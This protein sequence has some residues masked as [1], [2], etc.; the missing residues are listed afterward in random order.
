MTPGAAGSGPPGQRATSLGD[1]LRHCARTAL[2]HP[3][4]I[5]HTKSLAH[6]NH[7]RR[8]RRLERAARRRAASASSRSLV[9]RAARACRYY[10]RRPLGAHAPR[11]GASASPGAADGR[12]VLVERSRKPTIPRGSRSTVSAQCGQNS[13][14]RTRRA[15]ARHTDS[16]EHKASHS[17]R[18]AAHHPVPAAAP[19][20]V[21]LL[22]SFHTHRSRSIRPSIGKARSV[23]VIPSRVSVSTDDARVRTLYIAPVARCQSVAWLSHNWA[24]SWRAPVRHTHSSCSAASQHALSAQQA[25]ILWPQ[26][27]PRPP[28]PPCPRKLSG[29][30]DNLG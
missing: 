15:L 12:S 1:P 2:T 9:G 24:I 6:I 16:M 3:S 20:P 26:P 22:T 18:R 13:A 29:S 5:A 27:T 21:S 7:L 19:P 11:A 23:S 30:A 4:H 8:R 17:L 25:T 14:F 28:P 10:A